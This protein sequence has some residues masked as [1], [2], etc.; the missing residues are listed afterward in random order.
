MILKAAQRNITI[1]LAHIKAGN[2]QNYDITEKM[3]Q[4]MA[5]REK[6]GKSS[7]NGRVNRSSDIAAK[8]PLE[9]TCSLLQW[10]YNIGI[11]TILHV[12]HKL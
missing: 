6:G 4:A 2:S 5:D 9:H 7:V 1:S 12:D 11:F 3:L 10:W 8:W